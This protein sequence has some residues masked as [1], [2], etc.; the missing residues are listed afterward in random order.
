MLSDPRLLEYAILSND[1]PQVP[2]RLVP[3]DDALVISGPEISG[4]DDTLR[5]DANAPAM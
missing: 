4:D 2:P 1:A 5:L 3:R